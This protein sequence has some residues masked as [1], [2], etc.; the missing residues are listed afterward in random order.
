MAEFQTRPIFYI[1][2]SSQ[3]GWSGIDKTNEVA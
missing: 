3:Q 2:S 1:C